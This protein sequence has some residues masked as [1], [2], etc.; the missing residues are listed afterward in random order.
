MKKVAAL[1]AILTICSASAF[2]SGFVDSS[3]HATTKGGFVGAADTLTTVDKAKT[4]S[5]DTWV[6]L[7]GKI[8]K[9]VGSDDYIFRDN[10]GTINVEID[11]KRWEGQ[12]VTPKDTVKIQGEIDKDWNSVEVEVKQ[13][14]KIS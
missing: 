13:L 7:Q 11:H 5:D 12:T 4:Q 10:T 3:K 9:R 6:T 2:A 8:E 14:Q 1:T